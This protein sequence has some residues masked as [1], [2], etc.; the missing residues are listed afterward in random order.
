MK[1]H[2]LLANLEP[3]LPLS[4]RRI[5]GYEIH[6]YAQPWGE[7]SMD[8]LEKLT[9]DIAAND[10][11]EKI[12]LY[13]GKIL[14]GVNRAIA[15]EALG[16]EIQKPKQWLPEPRTRRTFS[17]IANLLSKSRSSGPGNVRASLTWKKRGG[18]AIGKAQKTIPKFRMDF[19]KPTPHR[20][21]ARPRRFLK[22]RMNLISFRRRPGSLHFRGIGIRRVRTASVIRLADLEYFCQKACSI[23]CIFYR[24]KPLT[25]TG[26]PVQR[27]WH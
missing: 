11:Q 2:P 24:L 16:I 6:P 20:A 13:E 19:V 7:I 8:E 5:A 9:D 21:P 23:M 18:E 12:V 26:M 14:D 4:T 10:L 1:P 15:L 25:Y 27:E 17:P 22:E 3:E